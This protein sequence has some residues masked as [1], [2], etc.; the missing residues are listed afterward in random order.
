MR[1]VLCGR[2]E[3]VAAGEAAGAPEAVAAGEAAAAVLVE[4]DGATGKA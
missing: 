4:A 2:A 1:L 3:A